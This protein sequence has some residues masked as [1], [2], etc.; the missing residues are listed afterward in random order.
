[1]GPAGDVDTLPKV[2]VILG[3]GASTAVDNG[4]APIL[5]YGAFKPPLASDLFAIG[6]H[7]EFFDI[8]TRYPGAQSLASVLSP[9]SEGTDFNLESRLQNLADNKDERVRQQFK[10][11]PPY[12][13]DLLAA[14]SYRYTHS[15]GTYL[16]LIYALLSDEPHHVLFL[17]LNYDT[18]LEQALALFPGIKF[19][20]VESYVREDQQAKVVKIHGSINWFKLIGTNDRSWHDL[21]ASQDV[22]QMP[23]E[24]SIYVRDEFRNVPLVD[25]YIDQ[26]LAYPI[27]TAP[28]AGKEAKAMVCPTAHIKAAEGF[29]RE[30]RKFLIVG[31]SGR[32]EDL[33]AL[34]DDA[35]PPGSHPTVQLVDEGDGEAALKRF[36][37]VRAFR[38]Q[39]ITPPGFLFNGG[40]RRY[41]DGG[42]LAEFATSN[43]PRRG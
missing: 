28:L 35:V 3:A 29:L 38:G 7:P 5:E 41:V 36:E 23:E 14:A 37:K 18:L 8:L 6:R 11:V 21:V 40:F 43:P 33:L 22:L 2:C 12:L 9:L 10:Q 27:L 30:C 26:N 24:G 4:S 16:Q 39:R 34:L 19:E 31:S 1:M 32:D 25:V 42:D 20:N 17:V 13:R 15:P